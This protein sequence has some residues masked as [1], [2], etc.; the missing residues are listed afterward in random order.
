MGYLERNVPLPWL[1]PAVFAGAMAPLATIVARAATG[2]L[3]ADPIA[4]SLNQLGLIALILLVASLA[5]TP[6]KTITG[7][8]WPIRI[9]RELGL[10]AFFYALLHVSVYGGL[11]QSFQF[12]GILA[13]VVKRKFIFVGF[14]AFVLL[15]PL[16][17]TS[18]RTAVR[19]LG[20][21]RWKRIHRLVYVAASLGALHFIWRVKKDLREPLIYAI[22][23][24][25]LFLLRAVA[26]ARARYKDRRAVRPRLKGEPMKVTVLALACLFASARAW[27]KDPVNA[28]VFG[29]TAI[30]GYDSVAYF[31]DGKPVP[32]KPEFDLEWMGAKWRFATAEHRDAFK[33]APE[34]FAP[35]YGGYCAYAVSQGRLADIDP[36]SWSIVGDKL[37]LNYDKDIQ[38]KWQ[39]DTAGYIAKADKNWPGVLK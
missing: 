32:G 15:I 9:R 18:T 30:H 20:F 23:L 6:L 10:L 11:D 4:E 21:V 34:K 31:T 13:D 19:R 24:A 3:G 35:Q 14:A 1:K 2:A 38:K 26:Y 25:A 33:S 7:W 17:A 29:K 37:Y 12:R 16:A 27:S 8:T 36:N 39:L 22:A 28:T 5:C